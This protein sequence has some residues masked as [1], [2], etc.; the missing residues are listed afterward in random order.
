MRIRMCLA[1]LSLAGGAGLATLSAPPAMAVACSDVEV[2]A[3]RGTLEPG[4]LGFI[5]GDPVYSALQKKAAG[6]NVTSY[7]VNYPADL[8]PTS[9]AQGNLDLV[10]HVK[11]QAAACPNQKFVLVGY[12]QGANVVD[13]SIGISSA[14]AVVGSP[15][16]ATLPA[17]VEPKVA[18]VLLFGNPIRALGKSVTGTYQSR[19]LD[20]CAKGDPVCESGGG[21][22]GAHL[23][24]RD[25]AEEAATFAAGRI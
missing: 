18:A 12:S 24:Y 17:A 22:V 5:V 2:V 15:I 9:A 23:S 16:V 21:D 6:K 4:T 7:K 13:N 11:S 10:N 19:T 25:D 3:A 14:G 20:L 8:S 1:A